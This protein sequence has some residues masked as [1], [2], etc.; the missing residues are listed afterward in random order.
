MDT[1]QNG[2]GVLEVTS[3]RVHRMVGKAR[4]I[5]RIRMSISSHLAWACTVNRC[6][7]YPVP[8]GTS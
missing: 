6:R 5:N 4:E 8:G 3:R 7:S 1:K 2:V